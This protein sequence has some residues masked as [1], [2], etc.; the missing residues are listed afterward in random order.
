MKNYIFEKTDFDY[1]NPEAEVVIAGITPGNSQLKGERSGKSK[2]EIKR[3]N[4]FGGNMRTNI[5]RM[6]DYVGINT[7]LDIKSCASLWTNDFDRVEMTSL[8]KEAT[9]EVKNDGRKV[10]FK[11]T[12]DIEKSKQLKDAFQQGFVENCKHYKK[13][14]IFVALGPGV[15]DTLIS[16]KDT[17]IINAPIIGIAHPS[18]ANMGRINCYLGMSDLKDASYV[19]CQRMAANAKN[20]VSSISKL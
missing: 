2:K 5:I 15:Y 3:E 19:W 17:G 8:L 20:I 10:M 12:K 7:L 16:L 13:A 1:Y 14:S 9:Y 11:N 6:L 18:G 4:A